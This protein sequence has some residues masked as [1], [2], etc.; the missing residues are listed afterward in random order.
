MSDTKV[1]ISTPADD[2]DTPLFTVS[3]LKISEVISKPYIIE[4]Y[5]HALVTDLPD[6]LFKKMIEG[7]C[8]ITLSFY[9]LGDNDS[10]P[11]TREFTG[12]VG[13]FQYTGERDGRYPG[14]TDDSYRIHAQYKA[15]LYPE[16]WKMRY[17]KNY[18]ISQGKS[19]FDII[20]DLLSDNSITTDSSNVDDSDIESRDYCVQY[21][22]TDFDY[23]S[24]LMEEEGIFYYFE[25]EDGDASMY[26]GNE[27][28]DFGTTLDPISGDTFTLESLAISS[29]KAFFNSLT[30][31]HFVQC[32]VSNE[33]IEMDFDFT[34]PS[35]TMT[36][37]ASSGD[38]D[39]VLYDYPAGYVS[40]DAMVVKR[41]QIRLDGNQVPGFSF[42]GES[43]SPFLAAGK[44]FTLDAPEI[45]SWDAAWDGDYIISS[46]THTYDFG[47][48]DTD[49]N[50]R[51]RFT[52]FPKDTPFVP[53]RI[54]KRRR[55]HGVDTAIVVGP[56]GE[57]TVNTDEYNRI[58]VY[59][60]WDHDHTADED[61][62]TCW[63]RVAQSW[64]GAGYGN[65]FTPRVGQEVL[66]S[67]ISGNPDRPI[68]TGGLYN[69][70]NK[71]PYRDDPSDYAKSTIRSQS[72]PGTD[73]D[74]FNELRFDDTPGAE[75]IYIHA[76][77]DMNTEILNDESVDVGGDKNETIAGDY[78]LSVGGDFNIQVGGNL[79]IKVGEMAHI[80]VMEE[81]SLDVL[82]GIN[83][84]AGLAITIT[85]GGYVSLTAGR[86][87]SLT[88]LEF[89]TLQSLRAIVKI[90]ARALI[91]MKSSMIISMKSGAET[92]M[93]A[94]A[95]ISAKA[96]AEISIEAGAEISIEAGAAIS[97]KAGA[98]ISAKAGAAISMQ[99][100]G[101]M[102]AKAGAAISIQAGAAI[103]AK[104][105]AEI[106]AQAGGMVSIQAGGQM[107]LKA[108]ASIQINGGLS[109]SMNSMNINIKGLMT[110]INC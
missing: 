24:R 96:G 80:F 43:T 99:A 103:S 44:L 34:T 18:V 81:C 62:T 85:A 74:E 26:L 46:I 4:V 78:N 30:K 6:D 106:S 59:F 104:A 60:P 31:A 12:I 66:V 16:I 71:P 86:Y 3:K 32:M 107:S 39:K 64:A 2:G 95:K 72:T 109:I 9:N 97:A 23:I 70:D 65:V 94:G 98:A 15:V 35:A 8:T 75:E 47:F 14:E 69:D 79:K 57:G 13:E 5:M 88:A 56:G 40:D 28:S 22:E 38:A 93:Q 63:I 77:N 90:Y 76:Q 25:H 49:M 51:N 61:S 73:P 48:D 91:T 82:G 7:S 68:V 100:G 83:V 11:V 105:G 29:D 52:A 55:I 102:S 21:G 53:E 1:S 89:M 45:E 20:T 84:G 54:T 37:D 101:E 92:T 110:M 42:L 41:S 10:S 33:Y 50:Y 36:D 27:N 87:V 58:Q 17:S 67:F 19:A 108:G